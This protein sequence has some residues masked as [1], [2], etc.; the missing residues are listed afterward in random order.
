M[1][2]AANRSQPRWRESRLRVSENRECARG[3]KVPVVRLFG[4]AWEKRLPAGRFNQIVGWLGWVL[5][6]SSSLRETESLV[7]VFSLVEPNQRRFSA[8]ENVSA[9]LSWLMAPCRK[10]GMKIR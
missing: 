3:G 4:A 1:K 10:S 9:I 5:G 6:R 2:R 7:G 8:D